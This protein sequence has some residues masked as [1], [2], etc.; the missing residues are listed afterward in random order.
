MRKNGKRLWAGLLACLVLAAAL[1][2]SVW[3]EEPV[4]T[5]TTVEQ[6]VQ[7][8]SQVNGGD[9]FEGKTVVL[10]ANLALGGE[11]NPWTA[12]GT[13]SAPFKGTFDGGFHVV[14]EL[15]SETGLFG[16]VNGGT[17]QDLVVRGTVKAKGMNGAGGVVSTLKAGTVMRCGNEADVTGGSAVAGVVGT[18]QGASTVE[19]CYNTGAVTGTVG[20]IG[21]VTGMH[22]SAGTVLSCY[23]TGAVTGPATV[24]GVA[25]GYKNARSL[26]MRNS[27]NAGAVVDSVGYNNNIGAV[28]GA[29]KNG[30]IENCYYLTGVGS[31]SRAG[32]TEVSSLTAAQLGEAFI[33]GATTPVLAWESR[34][35]TDAPVR[36]QFVERTELSAQLADRIRAA[37]RSAKTVAGVTDTLLGDEAYCAGASS[38]AT[39]W[40]ALA[41]GRFGY[42]NRSGYHYLIEDGTGYETYRA[43][44]QSYVEKT[45]AANGGVLH[46]TKATEWH[47]AVVA[48]AALGGDP[49][50]CGTYN[51]NAID[52]IADGSYNNSLRGGPGTQGLN[53]WI[54][55]LIALDT[56]MY[57]VPADAR[58]SRQTF[59]TEI[60]QL[61]LADGVNGNTYGGWV[62]GGYGSQSDVDMTAMAI[63]ALAPYYNEETVYTYTNKSTGSTVS[64]TVRQCVDEALDRLGTMQN[65]N[66][67]FTSWNTENAESI[68][69]VLV[70]LCAL[71]IDPAADSRFITPS[72]VTLLDGLLRFGTANGGFSHALNGAWNSMANDQA[73]YALVAY[74][75][76]ENRMRALYDM[77]ANMSD[78]AAAAVEA[79]ETA[80]GA[81]DDPT[82]ADYKAKLKT[83]L[84]AFRTVPAEEQRYVRRYA[85]LAAAIAMVGGEAALDTDAPYTVSL[86]I[87][88]A[89]DKTVYTEG[90]RFDPA[91]MVVT[92]TYSDGSAAAVTDYTLSETG[93]LELSVQ[94]VI[95]SWGVLKASVAIEVQDR[96]PWAGTGTEA[97][98]Y[99]I[100]TAEELKTLADWTN[101]GKPTAGKY[102]VLTADVDLSEYESWTPIGRSG[103]PFFGSFD[104]QGHA[105]DNLCSKQGGLFGTAGIVSL[106]A[107]VRPVIRNVGVASGTIN[108]P[109]LSWIGGIVGWSNGVDVINC[110]NGADIVCSGYSGGIVGTVRDGGESRIEGCYNRGSITARNTNVGG[111]VGHLA[112]DSNGTSVHVTVA[113]CYNVGTIAAADD[114]GGIVGRAQDGHTVK[115]CYNSGAVTVNGKNILTGAAGVVAYMTSE[116][117]VADCYYDAGLNSCGVAHGE[118]TTVGKTAQQLQDKAMLTLLGDAFKADPYALE[119]GGYPLLTWQSTASAEA[120]DA[121]RALVDAIGT[122]SLE[123]EEAIRQARAG[124]DA[125]SAELQAL[126]ANYGTLTAAEETL[127]QLKAAQ[128]T[129]DTANGGKTDS[130]SHATPAMGEHA[131]VL[132]AVCWLL[133]S[134][135]AVTWVGK[136]RKWHS[137]EQE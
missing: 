114:A 7:F 101:A 130:G 116:N 13:A 87:T 26:V 91:G 124:Y 52:L 17:V 88:K 12:I 57:T 22:L 23:N 72:G 19:E 65:Q 122:V 16:Y 51:G 79:A 69:Q 129:G 24:G 78:A 43:A 42:A 1:P 75:R 25:G 18:V 59:I 39:D 62:L 56:G 50:H 120:V 5:I 97:D 63:Q 58:Y 45:Y 27:Y 40:M 37:V 105:V 28:L 107:A 126:V 118:D 81:A 47:R 98:P 84:A 123:R 131:P 20:Y 35:C 8:A 71:G 3:A 103:R 109:N 128:N 64:K 15:W 100:G 82:A 73:T 2:L 92:V 46:T 6:L 132:A 38:T 135:A 36:P 76:L 108:A 134:V 4:L 117:T 53:G 41:M 90:D 54:W 95:V 49:T 85:A 104:G 31:D 11:E 133:G 136:R 9:S 10:A 74:W 68:A 110:W 102:F 32:V 29:W 67:G 94:Q 83:A 61:Q 111:I 80:I 115:R 70:A 14:S 93:G 21:G 66:G 137:T 119:N 77:R 121:V 44:L 125:L 113:D 60:L 55:G 127:A 34:I 33:D 106:N 99:R 96:I 89:P 48:L 86:E 112:A 30:T